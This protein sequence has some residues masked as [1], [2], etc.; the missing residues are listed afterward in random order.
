MP[1]RVVV[2]G[3]GAAGLSA[4]WA[5]AELGADVLVVEHRHIAAGS[6]GLSAGILNRQVADPR[7]RV[8]RTASVGI[9]ESLAAAG[10]VSI[11]RCGYLRL[12]RSPE[13]WRAMQEAVVDADPELSRVVTAAEVERMVPGIRAEDV[14]GAMYGPADGHIDGPE[15]CTAYLDRARRHGA[16]YLGGHQVVGATVTPADVRLRL[17]DGSDLVADSVINAAGPWLGVTSELLGVRLPMA[18]QRHAICT[19]RVPELDRRSIPIV[20]TYVP[21]DAADAV[22]VRPE[23]PG[24][25]LAGLHSYSLSGAAT[26][27]DE[28]LGPV[29]ARYVDDVGSALAERF[30]GWESA[31]LAPGWTGLYPMTRD[32]RPVIGPHVDEPRIVSC[33]GLGGVGLTVSGVVG[34]MAAEWALLGACRVL[35]FADAYLPDRT[36]LEVG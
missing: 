23:A 27:P 5:C 16:R 2:I 26:D 1:I 17:D 32:G 31:T 18:N 34:R 35:P 29:S 20:Q 28:P 36:E 25:L 3:A 8:M 13:Q 9:I 12:A 11:R 33:G 7:D 19:V 10:Q 30:P 21:G 15:L 6:S 14:L 24:M 4:A 22:Y